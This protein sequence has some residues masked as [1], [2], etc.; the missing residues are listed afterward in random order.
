MEDLAYN[1]L[2]PLNTNPL[3]GYL[4]LGIF[5]ILLLF[6]PE[7]SKIFSTRGVAI[8]L[9]VLLI[10]ILC[11]QVWYIRDHIPYF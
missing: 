1:Y 3:T 10:F 2:N 7:K 11:H 4:L 9:C 6:L 8:T 5:I